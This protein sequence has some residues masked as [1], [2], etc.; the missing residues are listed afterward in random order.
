MQRDSECR[1]YAEL[2]QGA[3][4]SASVSRRRRQLLVRSE[5]L[6]EE[7]LHSTQCVHPAG[8]QHGFVCIVWKDDELVVDIA[9]PEQLH[10]P[11]RL[12]E[13]DVSIVIAVHEQ[14]RRLPA[15]DRAD[16]EDLNDTDSGSSELP[17]RWTPARST[18]ALKMSELRASA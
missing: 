13:G 17:N 1:R 7:R 16:A 15:F 9:L 14:D 4:R 8:V 2:D 18:P 11:G 6:P 3:P 12:L 10:E 5:E